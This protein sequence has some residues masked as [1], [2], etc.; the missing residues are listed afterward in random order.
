MNLNNSKGMAEL[1]RRF[2]HLLKVAPFLEGINNE[3]EYQQ[4]LDVTELLYRTIGDNPNDPRNLLLDMIA[5]KIERYEYQTD[6]VLSQWDQQDGAIALIK[7]LMRQHGLTQ[8]E[9]PEIGSQ[10]VVSEV[11]NSKRPLNLRQIQSLAERFDLP[12]TLFMEH[13]GGDCR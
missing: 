3:N 6:P 13:E 10:G 8:A 12:V 4:A 11:L 5:Q 2:H 9:L 1:I 7:V